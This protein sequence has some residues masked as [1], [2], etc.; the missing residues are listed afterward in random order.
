LLLGCALQETPEDGGRAIFGAHVACNRR[1]T[2]HPRENRGRSGGLPY[3]FYAR[4]V[5]LQIPNFT[6]TDDGVPGWWSVYQAGFLHRD[7]SI[8]N[9]LM[10]E[11]PFESKR[12]FSIDVE[13]LL[14]DITSESS[15]AAHSLGSSDPLAKKKGELTKRIREDAKNI[16][17][18]V[19]RN[20]LSGNHTRA[21]I[22][23][24]DVSTRWL[25]FVTAD[26]SAGSISVR[27]FV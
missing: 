14:R 2:I 1:S 26:H 11:E 21:F 4:Y 3:A 16:K 12:G 7:I 19:L 6:L 5:L 18:L 9:I 24:F 8:G 13:E 20:G 25:G 17:E 23:D 10:V 27:C 22:M 15:E